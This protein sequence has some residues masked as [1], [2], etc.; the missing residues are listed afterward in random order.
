[1]KTK[2]IIAGSLLLALTLAVGFFSGREF[3][4]MRQDDEIFPSSGL[5][6]KKM[7]SDYFPALKDTAG[8]TEVFIFDSAAKGGNLLIVGGTH[9]NE[10]AGTMTAI[11]L[12][13]TIRAAQGKAVII[14]WANASGFTHSD[15]QEGSPQRF[16]LETPAGR[17][18]FRLGSRVTNPVHQWPDPTIY[19]NPMG[20]KLAGIEARNLNRAYPGKATGYLTEKV[21]FAVMALIQKEG[22]E[23]GIDLHESAPEYPVINAIVFHENA[24]EL[25]AIAQMELQAEG[26]E[27]RLE[28]SPPNLRGLTHREWGDAAGIKA[29]LLETPNASHGRLKGRPTI[30]LIVDGKDKYYEQAARLGRLFVPYGP[31]GIPLKLRVA[32]HLAGVRAILASFNELEPDKAIELADMPSPAD[33]Q[34]KGLGPFLK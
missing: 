12:A 2:H 15:P 26:F 9:P 20:Q 13:E 11:L 28:A 23:L 27:F 16:F 21:A 24:S 5:T 19:V 14:P 31:D 34:A 33:V 30:S 6:A 10:P 8:D 22:I 25:A 32:R 3:L 1:M 18:W 17:R 29:V 4:S 7:L